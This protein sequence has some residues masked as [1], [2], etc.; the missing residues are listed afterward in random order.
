MDLSTANFQS[1]S[2][3]AQLS[4]RH[5]PYWVGIGER[6]KC[7]GYRR[8]QEWQPGVWLARLYAEGRWIQHRLGFA[9]DH[10]AAD[11]RRVLTLLQAKEKA[12]TWFPAARSEAEGESRPRGKYKVHDALADYFADQRRE[13]RKEPNVRRSECSANA[14]IEPILGDVAVERLTIGRIKKWMGDLAALP[15]RKRRRKGTDVAYRPEPETEDERRG[16]RDSV[17]RVLTILKAAL[18]GG[19]KNGRVPVANAFAWREVK[20]FAKTDKART[21]ILTVDEQRSI[22]ESCDE[23]FAR[24]VRGGLY[25]GA[26]YGE[27]TQALVRDYDQASQKLYIPQE[28]AKNGKPRH[29]ELDREAK[30]F[31]DGIATDRQPDEPLFL[32]RGLPWGKSEQARAM[33]TACKGAG[34]APEPFYT[35]RHTCAAR[36][37][38]AGLPMAYVA[39]QLGNSVAICEKYYG[40]IEPGHIAKVVDRLPAVG[41]EV[42]KKPRAAMTTGQRLREVQ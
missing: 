36:W 15:A 17:N 20:P 12:L 10:D 30:R 22:L 32:R 38:K 39:A 29:I 4:L 23:D 40:H 28:I 16:R 34:F 7:V 8:A 1:R 27:L 26:R 11:G 6:G 9:D 35:L 19:V 13:G 21:R 24:L 2:R 25:C 33:Q 3:R 14:H 41:L 42:R 18:N 5:A 37:L 31:F